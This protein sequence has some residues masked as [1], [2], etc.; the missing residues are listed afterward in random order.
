M[1]ESDGTGQGQTGQD[2]VRRDRAGTDGGRVR[3]DGTEYGQVG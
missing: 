3:S 2:R 1:R